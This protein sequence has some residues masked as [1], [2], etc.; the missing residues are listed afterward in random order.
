MLV[1]AGLSCGLVFLTKAEIFAPLAVTA[2]VGMM[3]I[4]H[5]SKSIGRSGYKNF[6]IF[7]VSMTIPIALFL[8]YFSLKMPFS[9]ALQGILGDW[10]FLFNTDISNIYFFKN[11]MGTNR[12]IFNTIQILYS[13][14]VLSIV[15]WG[16]LILDRADS[17]NNSIFYV[18]FGIVSIFII[19]PFILNWNNKVFIVSML[20]N[21]VYRPLALISIVALFIILYL[22]YL[23]NEFIITNK[24]TPLIM[25]NVFGLLTLTKII[26]ACR[27]E[28]YGFA[29][30]MT[31]MLTN[32]ALFVWLIPTILWKKYG[33]GK[34]FRKLAILGFSL[35]SIY[36]LI[37]SN[38]YY[39]RKQYT[40]GEG[41]DAFLAY[42]PAYGLR[43]WAVNMAIKHIKESIPP[44]DNFTPIPEGLMVN[45]LMRRPSP[46]RLDA[47]TPGELGSF[48]EGA[49]LDFLKNAHPNF[50]LLI[51]RENEE[52][53]VGY[54]GLDIRNGKR[55]MDWI[56][57]NYT[58][59]WQL[60]NEPLKDD[61]FGMRLLKKNE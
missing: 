2:F 15:V 7:V 41:A 9:Q 1:L 53:G 51:H 28:H 13:L 32:V 21:I 24:M 58:S 33:R 47:I 8:I 4:S 57:N 59:V 56:K 30:A 22:I 26:L 23:K 45:Y 48:G 16:G 60:L 35:L 3:F 37:L 6:S 36:A 40:V 10:T 43:G 31:A 20:F 49:I 42:G 17:K 12:P 34:L 11:S 44:H 61:K 14:F 18:C 39:S 25:L 38:G 19:L 54:F 52:F 55:I 46:F 29:L 50:I 5:E 27:V